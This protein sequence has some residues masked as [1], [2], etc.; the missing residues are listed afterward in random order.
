MTTTLTLFD[1]TALNPD[2]DTPCT[3]CDGRRPA[4]VHVYAALNLLHTT[5]PDYAPTYFRDTTRRPNSGPCCDN[6]AWHL[7]SAWW[8][9]T[10]SCPHRGGACRLWIHTI[11]DPHP[12]WNCTRHHNERTVIWYEPLGVTA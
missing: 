6:C 9:P 11:A 7:A 3:R 8:N 1:L 12:G 4:T 2:A 5:H 10:C